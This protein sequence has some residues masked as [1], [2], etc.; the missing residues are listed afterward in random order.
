MKYTVKVF[1]LSTLAPWITEITFVYFKFLKIALKRVNRAS[2]HYTEFRG[3]VF[4][5]DKG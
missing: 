1:P 2:Q 4:K 5:Q 3:S